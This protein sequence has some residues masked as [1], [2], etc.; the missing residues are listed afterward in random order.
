MALQRQKEILQLR[1]HLEFDFLLVAIW[2][3]RVPNVPNWMRYFQRKTQ[4]SLSLCLTSKCNNVFYAAE[5]TEWIF[6]ACCLF[7]LHYARWSLLH[8]QCR[9]SRTVKTSNARIVKYQFENLVVKGER[10]GYF[11]CLSTGHWTSIKLHS[12]T[13]AHRWFRTKKKTICRFSRAP[14][15][16]S[17][18]FPVSSFVKHDRC[19]T[20][21]NSLF[22]NIFD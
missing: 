4:T 15:Q 16:P 1:K 2:R 12:T 17:T 3:W 14:S 6:C 5:K 8:A 7:E 19:G 18:C 20:K 21:W 13:A 9:S 22:S 11:L 10:I